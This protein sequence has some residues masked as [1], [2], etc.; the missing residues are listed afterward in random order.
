MTRG[1]LAAR[2]QCHGE[3]IR[4]YEQIGLLPDPPRTPAGHRR[5]Q[6]V[7]VHRL[8]FVLRGRE[9]GFT[10]DELRRLLDLVDRRAVTCGQ[11][12]TAAL[13][14]LADVKRRIADLRRMERTLSRTVARCAG[15]EVPDCPMIDS[16]SGEG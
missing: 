2:T 9:L 4:Y 6:A 16:L 15:G 10:V 5:Y 12:R 3:T 8:R 1:E 7:H 13:E 14:H 11:V